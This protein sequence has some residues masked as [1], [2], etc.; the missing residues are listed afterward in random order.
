M[1]DNSSNNSSGPRNWR[2]RVGVKSGMPKLADEFKSEP[3]STSGPTQGQR[4][5]PAGQKPSASSPA[6][7]PSPRP[8]A[9]R[10]APRPV[11][12]PA[13]MAPRRPAAPAPTPAAAKP[14]TPAPQPTAATDAAAERSKAFAERLRAQ[15]EAAE[16]LAKKRA[17][18]TRNRLAGVASTTGGPRFSFAEEELKEATVEQQ[19]PAP[20][21]AKPAVKPVA[22]PPPP[23]APARAAPPPPRPPF[24][25]QHTGTPA[26]A[27][28]AYQPSDAYRQTHGYREYDER[29]APPSPAPPPT[30]DAPAVHDRYAEPPSP[31]RQGYTPPSRGGYQAPR[32]RDPYYA[33]DAADDLFE[34]Q[35]PASRQPPRR[36][37]A[38]DYSA[39]YRDYDEAFDYD[40]E[41]RGRSG[42]W[43][44]VVLMLIVVAAIAAGA[45]WFINNG[46]KIGS[47]AT[48]N[49]KVPTVTA[50]Q[51]P[52]K[53]APKPAETPAPGTPVRR[54][55]IY[56]RILGNETLEPEKLV[57]SEETPQT[58]PP[59]VVPEAAPSGDAPLGVQPLPLPLPPPPTIP[60]VQGGIQGDAPGVSTGKTSRVSGL[61][62]RAG[63]TGQTVIAPTAAQQKTTALQSGGS[64]APLALPPVEAQPAQP[65]QGDGTQTQTVTAAPTVTAPP[66]VTA[67]PPIPRR[68][69]AGIIARARQVAEQRRLAAL[70]RSAA[71][72]PP[73]VPTVPVARQPLAGTGPVQLTPGT[74][75]QN[76]N[77]PATPAV[78][79]QPNTNVAS[80]PQPQRTVT[81]AP[82][83]PSQPAATGN[84]YVLQMSTFRDR[85]AAS[86]EYRRLISRHAS[87]LRGLSPEIRE[88]DLGV[89]G[90][91]YKL[92]LG[93]VASRGQAARLCNALIAAGEKDCLVRNR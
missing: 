17:E 47:S 28:P 46:T 45:Y 59:P 68:K 1:A 83:T 90:K 29:P 4:R 70:A 77:A 15:R 80:L 21:P 62:S 33:D 20:A 13:P 30:A 91:F 18:E 39:A 73:A 92:R 84:G 34:D 56:D 50:P 24:R 6:S 61:T 43:I 37:A 81:P 10:P 23:A 3:A 93:S 89:S 25:P 85:N 55:K 65:V 2:D 72:A 88:G 12:R 53:V 82:A 54:K 69:P 5:E 49:G 42:I 75:G 35:P 48:S 41:P 86:A 63:K 19:P 27:P 57:P 51:Q 31:D 66:P 87:L 52:V 78:P 44:F 22:P 38:D 71:P 36:A 58:P 16:A 74:G 64:Q 11:S 67:T 9:P 32:S 40:E 14:S 76:F 60:G 8:A 79:H 7:R 26:S